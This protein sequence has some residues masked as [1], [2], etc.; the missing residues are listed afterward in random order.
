M[1]YIQPY[2]GQQVINAD[3]DTLL[4]YNADGVKTNVALSYIEG[5]TFDID[6]PQFKVICLNSSGL[7]SQ[8]MLHGT[9]SMLTFISDID[10]PVGTMQM[11]AGDADSNGFS[12]YQK[13]IWRDAPDQVN[14]VAF[15]SDITPSTVLNVS[16]L[17]GSDN[18]TWG[19]P[20][21]IFPF[22]SWDTADLIKIIDSTGTEVTLTLPSP[23]D[24]SVWNGIT[25]RGRVIRFKSTTSYTAHIDGNIDG[26]GIYDLSTNGSVTI[27]TDGIQWLT[28]L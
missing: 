23:S 18:I 14:T 2:I 1:S 19:D 6:I 22:E 8:T 7:A 13:V 27:F 21:N 16:Q 11:M 9:G 17:Q 5:G 12:G 15:T 28:T 10:N 26:L 25:N 20:S 3:V 24:A 4:Y